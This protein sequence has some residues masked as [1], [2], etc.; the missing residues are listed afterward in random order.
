[1]QIR[2]DFHS[3]KKYQELGIGIKYYFFFNS[4]HKKTGSKSGYVVFRYLN[5]PTNQYATPR[6]STSKSRHTNQ[7][8]FLETT[9]CKRFT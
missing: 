1:M 6:K 2:S 7:I 5:L 3:D 9:F 8:S 4:F